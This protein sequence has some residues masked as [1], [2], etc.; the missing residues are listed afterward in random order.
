MKQ[1]AISQLLP[2]PACDNES[3]THL[4]DVK[5]H[6]LSGETFSLNQCNSCGL[7]STFPMPQEKDLSDYYLSEK[8]ISHSARPLNLF[9]FL[10]QSV[11]KHTLKRKARLS[12]GF[13]KGKELL[14]IGCATGEFLVACKKEGFEVTGVEPS[15]KARETALKIHNLKIYDLPALSGFR[16]QT[17]DVITMWHV[18]EHVMDINHR[19]KQIY[20]L[21]K[22]D[23]V[24]IMALP[25]PESFD[26]THYKSFWAAYDV[27]RHL[28]HFNRNSLKMLA[29]KHGFHIQQILPMKFDSFY[30][31]LLSEKYKSGKG[32]LLRAFYFGLKSNLY[33]KRNQNNY[34]S[35]IYI[36]SKK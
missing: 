36:I 22:K 19:L 7:I 2:C 23:G 34:S 16:D 24:L 32:S 26:A 10:Y 31:S 17:Y 21:L 28:F 11:R 35:L 33:A 1:P 3:F 9:E 30:I 25:N 20:R 14:D 5:D 12:A 15:E 6:F 4:F 13:S 18:L 29:H 8:Y 27:P